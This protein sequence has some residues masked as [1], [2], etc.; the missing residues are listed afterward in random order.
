MYM[1]EQTFYSLANP[2]VKNAFAPDNQ[3]R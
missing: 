2:V 1:K 3:G